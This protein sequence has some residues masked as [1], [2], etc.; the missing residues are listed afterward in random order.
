MT[1]TLNPSSTSPRGA[2]DDGKGLAYMSYLLVARPYMSWLV[3]RWMLMP[4]MHSMHPGIHPSGTAM[5]CRTVP[6]RCVEGNGVCMYHR[7]YWVCDTAHPVTHSHIDLSL[8][9]HTVRAC[10]HGHLWMSTSMD[11][12][13]V[14]RMH[15]HPSS[16]EY[17]HLSSSKTSSTRMDTLS[18]VL[19]VPAHGVS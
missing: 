7:P 1:C 19:A 6:H 10:W 5:T 13:M 9:L 16:Y 17:V 2:G 4:W 11:T 8:C 14:L 12:R 3:P 18:M 15:T